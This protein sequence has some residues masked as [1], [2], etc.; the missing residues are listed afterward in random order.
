[1]SIGPDKVRR[2]TSIDIRN[3]PCEIKITRAQLAVFDTFF[4]DTLAGGSLAFEWTHPRTAE[5][6]DARMVNPPTYKPMAPR[7]DGTEYWSAT[8]TIET[9]PAAAAITPPDDPAERSSGGFWGDTGGEPGLERASGD[10]DSDDCDALVWSQPV[11]PD[12]YAPFAGDPMPWW[13]VWG[14]SDDQSLL[15]DDGLVSFLP[16]PQPDSGG[17]TGA[18]H[19]TLFKSVPSLSLG[20]IIES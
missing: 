6:V 20:A 14:D 1:M 16:D 18:G 8:F 10:R 7:G 12:G 19:N 4:H 17:G 2:R 9:F 13:M 11:I 3:F 15:T 5:T